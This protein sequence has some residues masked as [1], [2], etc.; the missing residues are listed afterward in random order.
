MA[1]VEQAF[2]GKIGLTMVA[3]TEYYNRNL[4]DPLEIADYNKKQGRIEREADFAANLALTE[5]RTIQSHQYRL[6]ELGATTRI[7]IARLEAE[8]RAAQ[9]QDASLDADKDRQHDMTLKTLDMNRILYDTLVELRLME[10]SQPSEVLAA[11]MGVIQ[12]AIEATRGLYE[13][14]DPKERAVM[15][16][17]VQREVEKALDQARRAMQRGPSSKNKGKDNE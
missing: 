4:N 6:Q 12:S 2:Q 1:G 16:P 14:A 15:L 17:T 3:S 11:A 9:R 5:L 8:E 13:I 7:D 10:Q